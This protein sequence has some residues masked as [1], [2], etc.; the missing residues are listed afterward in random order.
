[1]QY[2]ILRGFLTEAECEMLQYLFVEKLKQED[3]NLLDGSDK[4]N[5]EY[6]SKRSKGLSYKYVIDSRAE[7]ISQKVKQ[8]LK[9]MI[10][11]S[12]EGSINDFCLPMFCYDNGG[13]IKA[14]R[15]VQ[16]SKDLNKYQSYVAVAQLTQRE[17]DF[18][19]GRFYLNLKATASKD[20]KTVYND[21]EKDRIYPMLNKGDICLFH[22]P[23]TV[24]GVD[25]VTK[26][27]TG[28][29][30]RLTCSWRTNKEQ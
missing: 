30:F 22:N 12:F 25:E 6:K 2:V 29:S 15:G 28:K 20:G 17:V 8:R 16:K 13:V 3:L 7:S 26:S 18:N 21:L 4:A 23:S 10:N 19:G 24:H 1:M 9:D 14:H 27:A 5:V 11:V